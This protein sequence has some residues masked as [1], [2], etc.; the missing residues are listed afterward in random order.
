MVSVKND[1]Q[2]FRASV[3]YK[4][5]PSA[6]LGMLFYGDP[7][8]GRGVHKFDTN[9]VAP[10]IGVAYDVFGDGKTAI[11]AGYGIYYAA[12]Y[13]DGI[14]G[15]QPFS[16]ATTIF[17]T[18][19]LANPYSTFPG[20]NPYP[21]KLDPKNPM[22]VLPVTMLYA[23]P[24]AATPYVQQYNLA[25]EHQLRP[26]LS[27]QAAYIGNQARKLSLNLDDNA[28][29]FKPGATAGNVDQRRP[30][31]P[32]V[33]G[34]IA[35]HQTGANASYN[36]LQLSINKRFSHGF[37]LLANY[38][39]AKSIDIISQDVWSAVSSVAD[40]HNV[41]LDRGLADG[42]RRHVFVMSGIW[43]L[44]RVNHWGFVG[45]QIVSGWQCNGMLYIASG[46]PIG[47][48]TGRDTN[49]DGV[50]NDRPNLIGNPYISGDRSRDQMI[51]RYFN[52]QAFTAAAPGIDGTLGR[53]V[54]IGPGGASA[55]LSLFKN[56]PIRERHALQFRS[57]F[58][59]ATNHV[60]LGNPVSNVNNANFGRI[61]SA[62]APRV[63]QFGL[64][65]S[66]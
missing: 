23:S 27:V 26:N 53:N 49:L 30:Y 48:A 28:P 2:T 52:T 17:G 21:Y 20:G 14:Y 39:F 36:S 4:V 5:F 65:Y 31:F 12:E 44:P 38:T 19:S 57:E 13:G 47:I 61:L 43:D 46:T 54:L 60:R 29:V 59:N 64:R 40:P 24:D 8:I 6:P 37:S 55:D 3:Q 63:V 42:Q 7:G 33:F 18:P 9:N 1:M 34:A 15:T 66:F 62:S 25:I 50:N 56:I 41:S 32:G 58:F 35:E 10:R 11:R 45:R 16:V 51:A 22:F